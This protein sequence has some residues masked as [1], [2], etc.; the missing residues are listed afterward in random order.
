MCM[1][2]YAYVQCHLLLQRRNSIFFFCTESMYIKISLAPPSGKPQMK[3]CLVGIFCGG[4]VLQK[5]NQNFAFSTDVLSLSFFI[6]FFLSFLGSLKTSQGKPYTY[7]A[8]VSS[9][10]ERDI[11]FSQIS[12]SACRTNTHL[13]TLTLSHAT[14][15][16]NQRKPPTL[17]HNNTNIFSLQEGLRKKKK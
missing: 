3:E 13:A 8:F 11:N 16:K 17:P 10:H 2:T 9:Q 4:G 14:Q 5:F 1:S 7:T 6:S 15:L 12:Y